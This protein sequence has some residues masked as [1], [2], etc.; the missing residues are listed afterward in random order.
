MDAMTRVQAIR[1]ANAFR[2]MAG[3]AE[4]IN[5]ALTR[6]PELDK[7]RPHA[8][9]LPVG[10]DEFTAACLNMVDHYNGLIT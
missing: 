10:P 9:P 4:K 7:T 8:W 5:S 1:L 3:A 6:S 2:E